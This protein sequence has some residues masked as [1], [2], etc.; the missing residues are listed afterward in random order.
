MAL[1]CRG[2]RAISLTLA[3]NGETR[4]VRLRAPNRRLLARRHPA[5]GVLDRSLPCQSQ[6][7]F[8]HYRR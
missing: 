3:A 6:A 1:A 8:E 7:G 4:R 2:S 5:L